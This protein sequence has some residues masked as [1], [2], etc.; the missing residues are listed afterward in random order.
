[1]ELREQGYDIL[2]FWT[3]S[4]DYMSRPHRVA[5]YILMSEKEAYAHRKPCK[6]KEAI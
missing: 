3:N 5:R 4:D 1:M 6:Y 2:T